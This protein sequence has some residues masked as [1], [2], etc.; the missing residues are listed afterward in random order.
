M[1]RSVSKKTPDQFTAVSYPIK[2]IGLL[3]NEYQSQLDSKMKVA[4]QY[5]GEEGFDSEGYETASE[6]SDDPYSG[7]MGIIG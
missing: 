4:K 3:L 7:F 6:Q 2:A 5:T 1:T